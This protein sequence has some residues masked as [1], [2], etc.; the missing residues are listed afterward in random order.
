MEV[1]SNEKGEKSASLRISSTV[2]DQGQQLNSM[3][4]WSMHWT[5]LSTGLLPHQCRGE[6]NSSADDFR[7]FGHLEA[8]LRSDG[9]TSA[10][11]PSGSGDLMIEI[12]PKVAGFI[13]AR[14]MD[15]WRVSCWRKNST[16][17]CLICIIPTIR[18][19]HSYPIVPRAMFLASQSS[20]CV[21]A[22][23]GPLP[24]RHARLR[25]CSLWQD[26]T[27]F[28][29]RFVEVCSDSARNWDLRWFKPQNQD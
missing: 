6:T 1:L 18:C 13:F 28:L 5:F 27:R 8:L 2:P 25:L 7:I 12:R 29:D 22:N 15:L 9:R 23:L 14:H 4:V 11:A 3:P 10:T 20:C 19:F 24:A 26:G 16:W 21:N 17:S